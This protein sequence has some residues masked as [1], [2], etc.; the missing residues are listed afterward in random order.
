MS[1]TPV[2]G[3]QQQQQHHDGPM[4]APRLMGSEPPT[5]YQAI[6]LEGWAEGFSK[7]F[8]LGSFHNN[9]VSAK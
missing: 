1:P 6:V 5:E 9:L 2:Q 7:L 3:Q 4:L 8:P